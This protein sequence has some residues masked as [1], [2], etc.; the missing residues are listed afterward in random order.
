MR[1]RGTPGVADRADQVSLS[2]ALAADNTDPAQMPV[3]GLEV[4]P[5]I[6]HDHVSIAVVVPASIHYNAGIGRVDTFAVVAGNV[7]TPVIGVGSIVKPGKKMVVGRPDKGTKPDRAA[8][9]R[10]TGTRAQYPRRCR[11]FARHPQ[12]GAP[13]NEFAASAWHHE[14][15]PGLDIGVCKIANGS[16]VQMVGWII[17]DVFRL[18]AIIL[19]NTIQALPWLPF[20]ISAIHG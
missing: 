11:V 19:R 16:R 12:W 17:D 6:H 15:R 14:P 10:I 7:D 3:Q 9:D 1:T 13:G 4:I 8:A 20:M 2:H 18:Y 5:V